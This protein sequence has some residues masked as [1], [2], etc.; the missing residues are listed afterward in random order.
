ME[1]KRLLHLQCHIGTETVSWA[2]LRAEVTGVDFAEAAIDEARKLAADCDLPVRFV[3]STVDDLPE[4]LDARFD[5]VFTS[6]GVIGWLPDL[7][8]WAGV[9]AHFLEPGGLFYI[10]ESHPFAWTLD[11]AGDQPVLKYEYFPG[12]FPRSSTARAPTRTGRRRWSTGGPM[13]GPG[14]SAR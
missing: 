3:C 8:H 7:E 5:I 4:A 10:A 1:G 2:R 9:V 11:D 13:S 12:R 14:P 6:W